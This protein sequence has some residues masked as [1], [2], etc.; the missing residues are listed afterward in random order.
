MTNAFDKHDLSRRPAKDYRRRARIVLEAMFMQARAI[1][2]PG[3]W[4]E[5]KDIPWEG[6]IDEFHHIM[7]WCVQGARRLGFFVPYYPGPLTEEEM[8]FVESRFLRDCTIVRF[9][10]GILADYR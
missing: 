4:R 8:Q 10:G 3:Q 5:P 6:L 7:N 9:P 2:L 1:A